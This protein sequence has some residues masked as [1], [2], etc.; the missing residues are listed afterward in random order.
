MTGP[1]PK[2]PLLDHCPESLP[3]RWFH[4]AEHYA[5]EQKSILA[6]NWIHVGRVNDLVPLTVKR[7]AVAGENLIL[8]K[9][10]EG[11]INCFH[12]TCRHRG[13]E[14]CLAEETKLK[15]KLITCPYH[16]WAYDL[17]GHLVRIP[18]ATPTSDFRKEEHGLLR[19][20]VKLWNGF[21]FV[22]LADT[23]PDFDLAPDLGVHALDN[24][25]MADLVTGHTYVEQM[26][27]T[28]KPSGRTTMNACIARPAP[29]ALR[30]CAI[31][32]QGVMA[33]N[34]LPGWTPEQD[35][36]TRLKAGAQTWSLN[37]QLCGPVFATLTDEEHARGQTFVTLW[38]TMYIVAHV[39]YVRAVTLTPIGPETTELRAQ[40]LFPEATVKAP[41]FDLENVTRFA[42]LVM[43]QDAGG[44]AMNQRGL[45]SSAFN[46]GRLMP[47][48]FDVH[49]FH[50]W[51]RQ[52]LPR[53][54][55][56]LDRIK[57]AT[58]ANDWDRRGLPGWTYHNQAL[59]E[60][61]VEDVFLRHW[62]VVGHINDVAKPGDYMAF[63]L[64]NERAFVVRGADGQLRAFHNLC[65]HRGSRIVTGTSGQC[66]NAMVCPFHGWVY[67]LDGTLR[68]AARLTATPNS[69]SMNS[70][71]A[72]LKWKS[73]WDSSSSASSRVRKALLPNISRPTPPS[74]PRTSLKP[75]WQRDRFGRQNCR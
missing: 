19:V 67:N 10:L 64:G 32:K 43:Q 61:E 62:Q 69:T 17:S 46:A 3:A 4:D 37:G 6:R 58:K 21:I 59:H 54:L 9:D 33:S 26:P 68:G 29:G 45:K 18:Y 60:L 38:P 34:E 50:Q 71:C 42:T 14:L 57:S 53:R 27:A 73:G 13:S 36:G 72:K 31:Y 75:W 12:N 2:S 5:L 47:Q 63:D 56:M 24:W 23:P 55:T 15:A 70:A 51:V 22:C 49:A 74:S 39:D 25:P 35:A 11:K 66:K 1:Q 7:V 20:N 41:G 48:E 40:W 65:R 8:V 52:Q 30:G 44:C 28:G 16:E